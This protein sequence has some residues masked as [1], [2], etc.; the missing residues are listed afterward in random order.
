MIYLNKAFSE[1]STR[2]LI[3]SSSADSSVLT[4]SSG[5]IENY[6]TATWDGFWMTA[7]DTFS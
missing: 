1:S 7:R 5:F 3:S 4:V 6:R 2:P